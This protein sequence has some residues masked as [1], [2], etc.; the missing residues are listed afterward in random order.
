MPRYGYQEVFEDLRGRIGAG[1]EFP[2]GARLPSRRELS[3]HYGVS[4]IVLDR[5][6]WMLRQE[7]LAETLPGIGVF[8][9][10]AQPQ[11]EDEG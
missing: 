3:E 5:V 7:G 10:E 11:A 4:D 9:P 8:V 1:R 6:M 2:P